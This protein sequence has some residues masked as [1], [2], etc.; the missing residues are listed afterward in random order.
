MVKS[1]YLGNAEQMWSASFFAISI[2]A[3][4]SGNSQ[5]ELSHLVFFL[6]IDLNYPA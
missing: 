6:I 4:V 1:F 3:K 2:A 5:K